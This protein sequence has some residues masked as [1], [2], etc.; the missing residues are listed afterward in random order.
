MMR[1]RSFPRHALQQTGMWPEYSHGEEIAD[2]CIHVTGVT[3]GVAGA[4]AL[5]VLT[6]PSAGLLAVTSLGLYGAGLV[7][8]LSFSA[9]YNVVRTPP[10]KEWLRRLDHAAIFVMIA[11][12]YT[13][14][15]LVKIGGEWGIGLA[16]YVWAVAAAGAIAKLALPRRFERASVMLYLALG[17]TVI[18]AIQP[19]LAHVAAWAVVMIAVGGVLYT[20]GV[21]FHLWRRLPYHNAVWHLLVLLAAAC[22]YAAVLGDVALPAVKT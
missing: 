16:A 14:F 4:L 21:A 20:V 18:V 9:L 8:M 15:A 3:A 12:S 17:W 10:L 6:L 7:A 13:P 22:H 2:L 1:P 11:G 5:L 19:L